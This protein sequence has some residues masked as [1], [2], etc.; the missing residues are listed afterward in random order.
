MT[1]RTPPRSAGGQ[2]QPPPAA[3]RTRW[4]SSPRGRAGP[5]LSGGGLCGVE[6]P[7]GRGQGP[8][9]ESR[10]G[11]QRGGLDH[12]HPPQPGLGR[13][14]A[15]QGWVTSLVALRQGQGLRT[16]VVDIEDIFD[17]FGYGLVTPQA[18]KDFLTH[19]YGSWQSPAPQ[20]VLL[21]GDTSYDYK[22]NWGAGHG[23]PGAG[24]SDLHDPPG[25]DDH[26]RVVR[27]GQRRGRGGGPLHRSAAGGDAAQA[28]AMVARSWP[29]RR[30]PTPRAGSG[31]WC[32]GRQPG[33][34]W[35][36]VFETMNED[37]AAL[38]PAGMADARSAS[39]C[40]STRTRAS[41]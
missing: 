5:E 18:V 24:V 8:R 38:L 40:R 26:R 16:A 22:D 20:Y 4:R 6:E 27:P 7:G 12:D 23:E 14:G 19:A 11:R 21:V 34:E 10:R 39:T 25:R 9:L 41:R 32:C 31:G 3:G 28:Q 29:T 17:E 36:A 37:A 35:E 1:S 15:E 2:R 33:R 13:R 30:P